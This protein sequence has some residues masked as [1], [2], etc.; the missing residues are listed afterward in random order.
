MSAIQTFIERSRRIVIKVGSS[1]LVD[2]DNRAN[3]PWLMTLAR[4]IADLHANGKQVVIVSSGAIALGRQ[5]LVWGPR[6]L[7][8]EEK[9]AAAACGQIKLISEWATALEFQDRQPLS[10]AQ[11]LLTLDDSENRRR[12]LNARNTFETLLAQ[13]NIIPIV[14]E[15]DTVAT[16]EIR[17]GD[18]DR[19]AARVAQMITA[20][21]LILLSDVAG[22]YT[23][24][25]SKN[26]NRAMLVREVNEIIPEIEAMAGGV[27][28]PMGSGGMRTKIEAAR[29]ALAAGCHVLISC[30]I[31]P[32]TIRLLVNGGDCTWFKTNAS[33]QSAR[34][35]WIS[36]KLNSRGT[37]V[38]DEGAVRALVTGKS[39]LPAGVERVFGEFDR[40]D[41]VTIDTIRGRRIGKG[42]S[43]YSS[44]DA[45]RII[46]A[47]SSEIEKI[48]GFKY[49]DTL[50][51]R[52]DLVLENGA[53]NLDEN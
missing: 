11:I 9:Q 21:L 35:H 13:G 50:I 39:L 43:E 19:L 3:R 28:S 29:I 23:E 27:G 34:K 33:P 26:P 48:L 24:D 22:L 1:L 4:D 5:S 44:A 14:N 46:G 40:G 41:A 53:A 25:P 7:E 45:S 31:Q 30:G 18:N 10:A 38:L 37:Y 16:E 15:N 32:H 47:Q 51:H 17:V 49:R 6:K 36:G 8:L 52:D 20:D 42:L 12:Y 2:H